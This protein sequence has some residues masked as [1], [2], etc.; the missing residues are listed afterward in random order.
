[1]SV[2]FSLGSLLLPKVTSAE[3]SLPLKGARRVRLCWH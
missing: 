3:M 1:M 2:S